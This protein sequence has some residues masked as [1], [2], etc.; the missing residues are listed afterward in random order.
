M[1]L[2]PLVLVVS[3]A[4]VLALAVP[5]GAQPA[6]RVKDIAPGSASSPLW[7][8]GTIGGTIVFAASDPTNGV[9]LWKRDGTPGGTV[10]VKDWWTGPDPSNPHDFTRAGNTLFFTRIYDSLMKTDG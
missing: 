3:L 8:F 7:D 2:R 1:L 10:L 4:A 9:E 5:L 6:Y